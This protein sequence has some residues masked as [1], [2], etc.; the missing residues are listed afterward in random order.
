MGG[1]RFGSRYLKGVLYLV[2]STK[3]LKV[4]ESTVGNIGSFRKD[5]N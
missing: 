1:G 2:Y 4:W 5:V 3:E